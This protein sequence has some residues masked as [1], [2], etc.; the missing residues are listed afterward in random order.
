MP[1]ATGRRGFVVGVDGSS[2]SNAA[3]EWAARDA[4][5]HHQLLI[6]VHVLKPPVT[7]MLP[8][9]PLPA[10][11]QHWQETDGRIVLE[12]AAAIAEKATSPHDVPIERTMIA[13]VPIEVLA[14]QSREARM[15]IVGR[16]GRGRLRHLLGSVGSGVSHHAHGPVVV[17][18]DQDPPMP[19]A[20]F[21]PVV[22]GIDGSPS[23][24]KAVEI[25]FDE[26]SRR[27]VELVALLACTEWNSDEHPF[28][29]REALEAGGAEL[30]A[31]RLAGW[32]EHYPDVSVRRVVV[33][34]Q[35]AAHLVEESKRAQLVVVGSHG[36]GGF[37]G[38]LLGSVS[39]AV[40][41]S[42][43]TPVVIART[44]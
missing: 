1:E 24:E 2:S 18:D 14:D 38:M 22:V 23:S 41:Q 11:F 12:E 39:S 26:A 5:L 21:A 32:Q 4:A 3:V 19:E 8:K 20:A 28:D 17:V 42:A 37:A 7:V 36:Y 13:G 29:Q 31:E 6:L 33:A 35:A 27:G 15:V 16:H 44:S 43:R 34:D 30:L 40:L 10:G 9:V 25:A